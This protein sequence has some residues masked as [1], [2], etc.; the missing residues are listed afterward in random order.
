M[1]QYLSFSRRKA[2]FTKGFWKWVLVGG[3]VSSTF[4]GAIAQSIKDIER[5]Q[6]SQAEAYDFSKA[7][8]W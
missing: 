2:M 1:R 8:V 3:L 4:L 5:I 6:A 7:F